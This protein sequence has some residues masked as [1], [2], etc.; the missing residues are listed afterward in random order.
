MR[1]FGLGQPTMSE[2]ADLASLTDSELV[3]VARTDPKAFG[4][5]FD[6]Y[7]ETIFR[8]CYFRL[9]DWHEAEDVAS[10]I[11]SNA[12]SS[13]SRFHADDAGQTFRAWLYGIARNLL[14][15]SWRYANRHPSTSIDAAHHLPIGGESVEEL[16]VRGE[17]QEL[18]FALMAQLPADQRELLELRLAGLS[19]AEIGVVLGRSP[20]A[21]RKA[22][23]RV[24]ATM[25]ATA[26]TMTPESG[27]RNG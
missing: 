5:L 17:E 25:R 6:R 11:F 16:V 15:N 26:E 24:F 8:F 4:V 2:P 1:R 23:S 12:F 19:A 21:V 22:Q 27:G 3:T 20:D 13:L 9:D 10:Q 7:W 18:L 14:G